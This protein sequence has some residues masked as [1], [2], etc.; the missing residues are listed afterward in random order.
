[1]GK[2]IALLGFFTSLAIIF[3]YVDTLIPVFAG[4]PGGEAGTGEFGGG[5]CVVW[6][7]LE[8]GRDRFFCKDSGRGLSF[9]ESF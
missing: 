5:V 8:G 1:M 9:R 3:G 7:W 6:I 4:I 2:K